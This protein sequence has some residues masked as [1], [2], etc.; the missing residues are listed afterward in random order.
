M[1]IH[2]IPPSHSFP[3]ADL[4]T[5]LSE[6]AQPGAY[7]F[8]LSSGETISVIQTHASAVLLA[9]KRAYKLKKAKDFGFFDYSTPALRRHFC[10]Q[11]VLLNARLAPHIYLGVAPVLASPDG[12]WRFGEIY[13]PGHIAQPGTVLDQG[14]VIDF[15]VV[16]ARLPEEA[17]LASRIAAG[18]V[19]P[20]LVASIA[21]PVADFH[22]SASTNPHI[23]SFGSLKVIGGNWEENFAQMNRESRYFIAPYAGKMQP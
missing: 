20:A 7:P 13:A 15:A 11:E 21:R 16:M 8:A 19:T 17:T 5:L 9:G 22:A 6:L 12:S 4:N 2:T 10:E 14:Q 23:A 1:I 18:T 3:A